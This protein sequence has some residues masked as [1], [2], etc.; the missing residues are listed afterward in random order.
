MILAKISLFRFY[1]VGI[2]LVTHD[3]RYISVIYT[4]YI[5]FFRFRF[6]DNSAFDR[7]HHADKI[8]TEKD[9]PRTIVRKYRVHCTMGSIQCTRQWVHKASSQRTYGNDY[10]RFCP[11]FVTFDIVSVTVQWQLPTRHVISRCYC[12]VTVVWQPACTI[13]HLLYRDY[14]T[15]PPSHLPVIVLWLQYLLPLICQSLYFDCNISSHS[16]VSYCTVTPIS[17]PT[18]LSVTVFWL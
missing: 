5:Y 1:T 17:P 2:S 18:H 11:L 9:A 6:L 8:P 10:W 7:W 14:A 13:C 15:S 12:S 3:F 4:I 16:S